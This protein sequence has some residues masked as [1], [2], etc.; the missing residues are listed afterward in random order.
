MTQ[1][2]ACLNNLLIIC[3]VLVL[4][5]FDMH[6]ELYLLNKLLQGEL[7]NMR[8]WGHLFF[9]IFT[10]IHELCVHTVYYDSS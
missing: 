10:I 4:C 6:V 2:V 7:K 1:C 8:T 3:F 5:I 9:V